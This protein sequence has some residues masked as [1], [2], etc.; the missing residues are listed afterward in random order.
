MGLL[1]CATTDA[2]A[3]PFAN[4]S[5]ENGFASWNLIGDSAV[6]DDIS[7]QTTST[8]GSFHSVLTSAPG[9][10]P[11][12][13]QVGTGAVAADPDVIGLLGI[14]A[15]ELASVTPAGVSVAE[16]AGMEQTFDTTQGGNITFDWNFLSD[17]SDA[18]NQYGDAFP[19]FA[20]V[21]VH[22]V[23]DPVAFSQIF[24]LVDADTEFEGIAGVPV[25]AGFDSE[26]GWRTFDLSAVGSV[27]P[28]AG[29]YSL[30]IAVFDMNDNLF[31]SGL[32]VDNVSLLE[33]STVLL[34]GVGPF[35]LLWVGRER[36][37]AMPRSSART[38]AR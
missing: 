31:D 33:P 4:G 7:L 16:G 24:L 38:S 8:T 19:D 10:V 32:A 18:V 26:T 3:A 20:I 14:S 21:H 35:G 30:G 11:A 23:N 5:F 36:P 34:L 2:G 15:T 27:L 28:G 25:I 9:S 17:E 6:F 1:L 13:T 22:D 29:T 37:D 12:G